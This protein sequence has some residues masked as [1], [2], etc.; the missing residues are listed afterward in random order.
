MAHLLVL[1][2]GVING[3]TKNSAKVI[4]NYPVG[5]YIRDM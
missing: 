3:V 4:H 1:E 5:Q 2:V